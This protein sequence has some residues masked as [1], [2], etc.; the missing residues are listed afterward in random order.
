MRYFYRLQPGFHF[1]RDGD[2]VQDASVG[3][4]VPWLDS[5]AGTPGTPANVSYDVAWPEQTPTLLV[6]ET[7]TDGRTREGEAVGLPNSWTS[8]SSTSCTTR[9]A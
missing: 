9:P 8:A 7:L 1:D 6:G 5:Y 3:T 2:G 4:C